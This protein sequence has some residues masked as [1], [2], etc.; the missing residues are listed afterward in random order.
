MSLAVGRMTFSGIAFLAFTLIAEAAAMAPSGPFRI[1]VVTGVSGTCGAPAGDAPAGLVAYVAHLERR[2]ARPVE[3]CPV[4]DAAEAARLLADGQI[5][6]AKLDPNAYSPVEASVRPVL[7]PRAQGGFGRVETVMITRADAPENA[8]LA[9][10]ARL[11]F[12]GK[13]PYELD[14]PKRAL[15]D[16]G[17]ASSGLETA[18][19]YEAAEAAASG[20]RQG[21]IST[22]V[23]YSADWQ[24]LCRP[25]S[26]G[27]TPCADLREV[28]RGRARAAEA[29]VV[30]RDID[31]DTRFRLVG[32]HVAL[33]LENRPAFEW[34][35]PGAG[36]LEPTEAAAL[37]GA[38]R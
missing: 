23:L 15:A 34:I 17:V 21:E 10:D 14:L 3:V 7:T 38:G 27:G 29:W 33:H 8:L 5:A 36:E 25:K 12:A 28:F 37:G 32:I 11:G 31:N 4:V 35:A 1:G 18:R 9:P 13:E 24:R 30:R 20:L 16:H 19:I 6:F 22:L 2:L 26:A